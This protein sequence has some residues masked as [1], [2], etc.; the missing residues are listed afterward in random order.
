MERIDMVLSSGVNAHNISIDSLDK[1]RSIRTYFKKN[2]IY[3]DVILNQHNDILNNE[4]LNLLCTR[5]IDNNYRVLSVDDDKILKFPLIFK[6]KGKEIKPL[7]KYYTSHIHSSIIKTVLLDGEGSLEDRVSR[8][9]YILYHYWFTKYDSFSK[10]SH[11][12]CV[13]IE[14][15]ISSI[16][17]KAFTKYS[18]YT[19]TNDVVEALRKRLSNERLL[20]I[21][22]LQ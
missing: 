20:D 19:I 6:Y 2:F 7:N 9:T 14:T 11:N 1:P 10:V 4:E 21:E 8:A 12:V 16:I 15:L 17:D 22:A 18:A 3:K 13:D 5:T